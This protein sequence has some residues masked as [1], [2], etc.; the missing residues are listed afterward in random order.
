MTVDELIDQGMRL[1]R[2]LEESHDTLM[3]VVEDLAHAENEYRKARALEWAGSRLSTA[4]AKAEFVNGATADLRDTR[5]LLEGR[6]KAGIEHGRNLRQQLSFVQT[7]L[8]VK[9]EE[10]AFA[11][12]GPDTGP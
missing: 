1:V 7:A 3:S 8:N 12:T 2:Q 4:A 5:D 10:A 11:R 9:R 6:R